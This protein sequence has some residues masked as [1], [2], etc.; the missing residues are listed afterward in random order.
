M[1]MKNQ[2]QLRIVETVESPFDDILKKMTS[3]KIIIQQSSLDDEIP[4]SIS[5]FA[6]EVSKK[7]NTHLE[8][9]QFFINNPEIFRIL[10]EFFNNLDIHADRL[11]KSP[12]IEDVPKKRFS[13]FEK[14]IV[15]PQTRVYQ[16]WNVIFERI[17]KMRNS[18]MGNLLIRLGDETYEPDI[19]FAFRPSPEPSRTIKLA[20]CR[21]M[22][23]NL[24]CHNG[25]NCKFAHSI[26]E[27]LYIGFT[28][29]IYKMLHWMIK[30]K[31]HD[32]VA[33]THLI[34]FLNRVSTYNY[35]E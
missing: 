15:H 16:K 25:D 30:N 28:S 27:Q 32:P 3:G 18:L 23:N 26:D 14:N 29:F 2:V 11:D 21:D 19:E 9:V 12:P 24:D 34:D 1:E 31:C 33:A 35:P 4:R 17:F 7:G 20:F 8:I 13:T 22:T 6:N 10:K 5:K